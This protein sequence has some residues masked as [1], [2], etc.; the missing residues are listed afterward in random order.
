MY[1][2]FISIYIDLYGV[3]FV[4][5]EKITFLEIFDM[6]L[7]VLSIF[8]QYLINNGVIGTI[9][10]STS[11]VEVSREFPRGT[12]EPAVWESKLLAAGLGH[13]A[14]DTW[15]PAILK[16]KESLKTQIRTSSS[17]SIVWDIRRSGVRVT[18]EYRNLNCA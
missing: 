9:S 11:T 4:K 3:G 15:Q 7:I 18:L 12:W 8:N 14:S 1:I 17:A 13:L 10:T 2:D 5:S 6:H 16:S